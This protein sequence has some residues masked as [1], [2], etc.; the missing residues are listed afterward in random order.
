[1]KALGHCITSFIAVVLIAYVGYFAV[2][3]LGQ[4]LLHTRNRGQEPQF[5]SIAL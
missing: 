2:D 4:A 3:K 5:L 1:V